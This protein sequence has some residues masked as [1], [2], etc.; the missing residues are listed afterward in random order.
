MSRTNRSLAAVR[1]D[2]TSKLSLVPRTALVIAASMAMATPALAE[3]ISYPGGNCAVAHNSPASAA[4]T[5]DG[6]FGTDSTT[7]TLNAY[8]PVETRSSAPGTSGAQVTLLD[9]S[10]TAQ[11][12]CTLTSQWVDAAGDVY[13]F[14]S[15]PMCS[16]GFSSG[17]Q[18]VSTAVSFGALGQNMQFQCTVPARTAN[19]RS[20]VFRYQVSR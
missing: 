15:A 6:S 10:S 14:A 9:R 17:P 13:F 2:G 20:A 19:G 7:A 1:H 4:P 18:N 5:W 8:C 3:Q 11:A 16:T 12:C